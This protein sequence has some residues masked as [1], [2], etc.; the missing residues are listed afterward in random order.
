VALRYV[1]LTVNLQDGSGAPL[2]RGLASFAPSVFLTDPVDNA[3]VPQAPVGA[4]F[5]GSFPQVS[6]LAT[7]NANLAPS[8]W[9]WNVS[10]IVTPGN[11]SGFS[12]FL[13]S[14]PQTFTA[15]NASPCVFTGSGSGYLNN[16]GVQLSGN[17]LPAPFQAGVTYWTVNGSGAT[18]ELAATA[19]GASIA[20]TGTGS[21]SVV[22]V[23]SYLSSLSPVASVVTMQSYLPLPSGT[24]AAGQVPVATGSG[25]V[26]AWGNVATNPMTTSGDTIYGGSGGALT[27]LAGD[28]SNTRKFLREQSSGGVAQPP[29]W[30]TLQ[31]GDIPNNAANTS[32]T[33]AGLSATLA[34]GSGGTGQTSAA[35]AYNSLSPMT[36]LGDIE[37]ES[38]AN[39]AAR[40]AGNTASTKKFLTQAGTGSVSAAPAWGTIQSGDLPGTYLTVTAPSGDSTGAT[41]TATLQAALTAARTAGGGLVKGQPGATYYLNSWL[42]TGSDTTLDLTDCFI[43]LVSG[44]ANPGVIRNYS[45]LNPAASASDASVSSGSGVITTSLGAS[46]VVGQTVN[47]AGAGGSGI[48]PLTGLV[49]A[50]TSTT[51]TVTNLDG[52]AL[53]ATTTVSA[54]AVTLYNRDSNIRVKGGYWNTGSN[55]SQTVT[56]HKIGLCH[57]DHWSVEVQGFAASG[58]GYLIWPSDV[59]DGY[60]DAPNL[61]STVVN[62]DGVH[63]HG[64]CY[65]LVV[66]R[67]TGQTG[68]DSLVLTGSDNINKIYTAGNIVGVSIG[69]TD[70]ITGSWALRI[71]ACAGCTIDGVKVYGVIGGRNGNAA[72]IGDYASITQ[73][74]G[75]TYGCIDV[76]TLRMTTS[77]QGCSLYLV[78]PAAEE[79]RAYIDNSDGTVSQGVQIGGTSTVT[80]NSLIVGGYCSTGVAHEAASVTVRRLVIDQ[81]QATTCFLYMPTSGATVTEADL[82]SCTTPAAGLG[83]I[84]CAIRVTAGAVI[85]YANFIGGVIRAA[86]DIF[87]DQSSCSPVVTFSGGFTVT[88]A[89][90]VSFVSGSGGTKTFVLAGCS[91]GSIANQAF[92]VTGTVS[93]VF[94]GAAMSTSGSFTLLFLS[95]SQS[96]TAGDADAS[97]LLHTELPV[98]LGGTGVATAPQ[99]D[100]FAGPTSGTGAPSFRA[101]VAADVPDLAYVDSVSATDSSITIT[102]AS[103][104]PSVASVPAQYAQRIFA[105]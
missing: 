92:H 79:I 75:G 47:V 91:F 76:G 4:Q 72:W 71:V 49:S 88:S 33:A 43:T 2:N 73:M 28:T 15:T 60:V 31:S 67:V 10:F 3:D 80:I 83:G 82:I 25:E 1:T 27:R 53:T 5:T 101:L 41:D 34:V 100:V 65:G 17:S 102:G 62:A 45:I 40:L 104:T 68:D 99:N 12:F 63:V 59:T 26:S 19:G 54:A 81:M 29:A 11:P 16:T 95:A 14:S 36:T 52:T 30:D 61:A 42:V 39:T 21:G 23:S 69:S 89:N 90:Y 96:V 70:V 86:N 64:P 87:D 103:D 18:F 35:A 13:P 51:I 66:S 9:A 78:S 50:A 74:V 105:V 20:S 93:L 84:G 24:P 55:G 37:Y 56:G 85:G 97:V 38:G 22:A 8:G 57:V 32:G 44:A 77:S 46:A 98:S 7:D 94:Y 48:S 6:L 58:N